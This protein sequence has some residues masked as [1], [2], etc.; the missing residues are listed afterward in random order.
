M[1]LWFMKHYQTKKIEKIMEHPTLKFLHLS[2]SSGFF[3]VRKYHYAFI[4][5]NCKKKLWTRFYPKTSNFKWFFNW[6]MYINIIPHK[7]IHPKI[8]PITS[9]LKYIC[10]FSN[11]VMGIILS[12]LYFIHSSFS[13]FVGFL[14][15][16]D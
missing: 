1:N 7:E 12:Q 8:P 15:I 13:M 10:N 5:K 6:L 14:K 16:I 4:A 11:Y 3:K 9:I 2:Y